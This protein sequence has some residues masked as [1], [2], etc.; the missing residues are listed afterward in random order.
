MIGLC[1]FRA[2]GAPAHGDSWAWSWTHINDWDQAEMLQ[3]DTR[4]GM[5]V[6]REGC[7]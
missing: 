4:T 1:P 6:S 3:T 7:R 2:R 5:H